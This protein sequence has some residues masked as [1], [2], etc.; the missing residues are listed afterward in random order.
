MNYA[1]RYDP[2]MST[3]SIQQ[4]FDLAMERHQAGRLAEAEDIYRQIIA[5]QPN[6]ADALHLLGVIAAQSGRKKNA[7]ELIRR[8]ITINPSA[9]VYYNNLGQAWLDMGMFEQAINACREALRLNPDFA[10]ACNIMGEALAGLGRSDEA[11]DSYLQALRLKPDYAEVYNNLGN[12]FQTQNRLEEAIGA[13]QI[14]L[15]LKPDY[16]EVYNNLGKVLNEKGLTREALENY[17]A[18]IRLKP[19]FAEAHNNLGALRHGQNQFDEAVLAYRRAITL[20]ANFAK[21]HNNLALTLLTLGDFQHGWEEY[22]WR[23][24][25]ANLSSPRNFAQPQWDGSPLQNRTLFLHA[26]QG[27][28]DAIQFI[29]YLPQV[30]Q[31]GGKIIIECR[32][33]LQRLFWNMPEKYQ[34]VV[35]GDSLPAFDLHCPL[36]SLPLVFGT[37]LDNIPNSVPYLYAI[38]QDAKSW[39]QRMEDQLPNTKVSKV[40]LVWAGSPDN[41]NDRNRSMKLTTLAPLGQ[42]PGVRFFSLQRGAAAIQSKTPPAGMELIDWAG[43]LKDFADNAAL[44]ANLDLVISVDTSMVHLAGAMGKPVWPLLSFVSDWR[45]LLDREDSPWYPTMRLFRQSVRGDWD[46]VINRVAEALNLWIKSG[47]TEE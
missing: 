13:Y 31:R 47:F 4:T 41:T 32:D 19:D 23:W 7:V 43:E 12:A 3:L 33:D 30:A 29:R 38:A 36:L 6:H 26:E 15:R 28:G 9:G 18:A 10:A 27:F 25:S 39:R 46:S 16:P 8:A 44:I 37:K 24:K 40:G 1:C 5:Q 42:V 17:Q 14:A 35:L 20:N 11:I 45:W 22:E 21:A 34:I 2:G